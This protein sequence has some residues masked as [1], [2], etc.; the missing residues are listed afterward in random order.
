MWGEEISFSLSDAEPYHD[1]IN[2]ADDEETEVQPETDLEPINDGDEVVDFEEMSPETNLDP[3]N[4][5]DQVVGFQEIPMNTQAPEN[6]PQPPPSASLHPDDRNT[7]GY[8]RNLIAKLERH[9]FKS[10]MQRSLSENEILYLCICHR[11]DSKHELRR[12]LSDS[13]LST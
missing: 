1:V 6:D 10:D 13:L 4:N 2:T 5:A 11:M 3:I 12:V 7:S 8:N 9:R